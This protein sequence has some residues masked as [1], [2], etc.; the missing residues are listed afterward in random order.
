ML[1][2]NSRTP[3]ADGEHHGSVPAKLIKILGMLSS[4]HAGERDNAAR[5]S[6]S[7]RVIPRH[8][9]FSKKL[10]FALGCLVLW[11]SLAETQ[12]ALRYVGLFAIGT[13]IALPYASAPRIALAALPETQ[14]GKRLGPGQLMPLSGRYG[15]IVLLGLFAL[16]GAGLAVRC[17]RKR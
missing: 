1:A 13:G 2:S 7:Y 15:R 6:P 5:V 8:T 10:L 9:C 14:S 4:E 17:G 12:P 3:Q 11:I 16:A